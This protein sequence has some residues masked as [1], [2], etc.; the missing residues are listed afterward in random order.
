METMLVVMIDRSGQM[1]ERGTKLA[2][3]SKHRKIP[4]FFKNSDNFRL[5]SNY[6]RCRY[7]D[8]SALPSHIASDALYAIFEGE[9][10][11][12]YYLGENFQNRG[13]FEG[14]RLDI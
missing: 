8:K 13:I 14:L 12:L 5:A 7:D 6:S 10:V 3:F 2:L 4:V 1:S 11:K 9:V